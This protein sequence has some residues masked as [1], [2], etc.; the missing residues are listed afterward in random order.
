MN[1]LKRTTPDHYVA[2]SWPSNY[3]Q[4]LI[5][6]LQEWEQNLN[7]DQRWTKVAVLRLKETLQRFLNNLSSQFRHLVR[8][9]VKLN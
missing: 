6:S 5:R 4:S 3:I 9:Q 1:F 7:N 2:I 8:P